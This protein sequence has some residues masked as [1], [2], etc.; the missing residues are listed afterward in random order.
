M[1]VGFIP[2]ENTDHYRKSGSDFL[3]FHLSYSRLP[4]LAKGTRHPSLGHPT[5]EV[6]QKFS[7]KIW[8]FPDEKLILIFSC[9]QNP[10][11]CSNIYFKGIFEQFTQPFTFYICSQAKK[12]E[13]KTQR[14]T[15]RGKI[16]RK[17]GWPPHKL[18]QGF[19]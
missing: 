2:E 8:T 10:L 19:Q 12:T 3:D 5:P 17:L 7:Q 15:Q 13:K 11:E 16:Q 1:E 18:K 14:G 6:S 9:L 4:E